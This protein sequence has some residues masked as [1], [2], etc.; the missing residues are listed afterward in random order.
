[1]L[2]FFAMGTPNERRSLAFTSIAIVV[3]DDGA[4]IDADA[5]TTGRAGL[6]LGGTMLGAGRNPVPPMSR[7]SR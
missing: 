7:S 4:G 2:P 6:S 1:M 5:P 3:E